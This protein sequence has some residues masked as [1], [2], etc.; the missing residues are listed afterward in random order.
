MVASMADG[1]RRSRARSA[2]RQR[3]GAGHASAYEVWQRKVGGRLAVQRLR[4]EEATRTW[5]RSRR[6][7]SLA[8]DGAIGKPIANTRIYLLDQDGASFV[9]VG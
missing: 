6:A 7:G 4:P 2:R 9:G 1:D 8:P 5:L 3:N